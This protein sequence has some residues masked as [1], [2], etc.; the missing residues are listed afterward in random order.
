MP[1]A[2]PAVE[3]LL[4]LDD[5]LSA[6]ESVSARAA[7]IVYLRY[8]AGLS[9]LEIGV[10]LGVDETTVRRDWNKAR[11]WLYRRIADADPG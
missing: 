2:A 10:L 11:G 3:E 8:F 9:D 1:D 6:L 4:L 7:E 5:A